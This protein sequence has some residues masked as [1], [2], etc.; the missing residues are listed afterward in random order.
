MGKG[1]EK[2]AK[3]GGGKENEVEKAGGE[4]LANFYLLDV[5]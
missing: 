1:V 2:R 3:D 5:D 4:E